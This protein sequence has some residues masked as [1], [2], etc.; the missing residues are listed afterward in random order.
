MSGNYTTLILSIHNVVHVHVHVC[1][2]LFACLFVSV[3]V[4]V[5]C[6]CVL[7]LCFVSVLLLEL[8][9]MYVCVLT[10]TEWYS[11]RISQNPYYPTCSTFTAAEMFICEEQVRKHIIY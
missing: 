10:S 6:V 11:R 7:C 5:F 1:V 2:C 4:S 3:S 9:T 8:V